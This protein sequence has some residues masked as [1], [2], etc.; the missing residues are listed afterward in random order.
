MGYNTALLILNDGLNDIERNPQRF[1][2]KIVSAILKGKAVRIGEVEVM[3]TD[4]ADVPRL[5]FSWRNAMIDIGPYQNL[6][7]L[8]EGELGFLKQGLKFAKEEIAVL[9]ERLKEEAK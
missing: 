1:V 2:Q 7:I 9:E 3:A 4:H 8:S 6:N 5:Y